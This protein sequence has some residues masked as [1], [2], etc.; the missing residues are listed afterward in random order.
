MLQM[1]GFKLA[2]ILNCPQ[3]CCDCDKAGAVTPGRMN[4]LHMQL[5]ASIKLRLAEI[6]DEVG[7]LH[8]QGYAIDAD[9][10][11][12]ERFELV[13]TREALHRKLLA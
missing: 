11:L 2:L 3:G 5:G 6:D 9:R 8:A 4:L 7:V 10:L 12:E 1:Q 13:E